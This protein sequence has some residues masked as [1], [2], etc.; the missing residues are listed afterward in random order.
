MSIHH[1]GA[2]LIT[3]ASSG[4]GAEY[5]RQLAREGH[6]LVLV[7]R[8]V[9]RL[10]KLASE[11]KK[12]HGV[13]VECLAADLAQ[14]EGQ[15]AVER[16]ILAEPAIEGLINNAGFGSGGLY[17]ETKAH[18]QMA[19]IAAHVEAP[20]RLIRA[21]LPAMVKRRRGFIIN[22]ASIAAFA[23]VPTSAMY[24]ST[25]LWMVGFSQALAAELEGTGVCIQALC[26]GFTHTEFHDTEEYQNFNRGVVPA[27]CWMK[28]SEVV[29][30]SLR[31]LE[32]GSG[33]FIPGW[34]NR[35][36]VLGMKM[37]GVQKLGQ[38]YGRRR[39]QKPAGQIS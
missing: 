23:M 20:A 19:M 35:L 26:P 16:R 37:P 33:V 15:A 24:S 28:A 9:E 32:R 31:A 11:L 4:I 17:H 6:G 22:V 39:W 12:E 34:V 8:R 21:V 10:E 38:W 7:A 3:G 30:Q 25:K 36:M 27:F 13:E 14:E 1:C 29:A 2:V 18:K 5:A